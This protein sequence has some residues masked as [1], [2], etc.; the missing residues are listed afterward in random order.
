MDDEVRV[1]DIEA[2][3]AFQEDALKTLDEAV[4][5]QQRRIDVLEQLCAR[6]AARLRDTAAADPD[7]DA[8]R[9]PPHY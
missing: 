9:R 5:R 1:T 4:Y 7:Q 2:R 6:L 8:D 3:L